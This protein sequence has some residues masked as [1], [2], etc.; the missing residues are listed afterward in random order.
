MYNFNKKQKIILGVLIA[1]VAGFVCY[2]VYAQDQDNSTKQIDFES[3]VETEENLLEEQEKYSDE[4][5]LVHV[6][7]AVNKEGLVELKINSRIAEAI[8]KAGGVKENASTEDINL[9]YK[10]EDGMK[11]YIPTKQEKE[12]LAKSNKTEDLTRAIHNNGKWYF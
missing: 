2:Y 8:D 12:S 3:N 5:I 11:I 4:R 6:S 9:A 7:G 10:L 1:V